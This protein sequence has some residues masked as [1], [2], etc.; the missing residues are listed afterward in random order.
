M[1]N[2]VFGSNRAR[3]KKKRTVA[4]ALAMKNPHSDHQTNFRRP[5]PGRGVA[6]AFVFLTPGFFVVPADAESNNERCYIVSS[7][8]RDVSFL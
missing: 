7:A 3:G 6:A 1:T 2:R 4:R 5:Q 8:T